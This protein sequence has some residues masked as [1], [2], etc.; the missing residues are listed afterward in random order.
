MALQCVFDTL[1]DA[2]GRAKLVQWAPD[3]TQFAVAQDKF[4]RVL[5][6]ES[7]D[8]VG[9]AQAPEKVKVCGSTFV[10]EQAMQS[11]I[12]DGKTSRFCACT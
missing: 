7:L 11:R 5:D 3:G 12:L 4:I 9:V 1:D 8:I 10:C 6:A 2:V